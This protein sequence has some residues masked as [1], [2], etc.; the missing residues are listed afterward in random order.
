M[1]VNEPRC[2]AASLASASL[3]VLV[4]L[5]ASA[6]A[7]VWQR[8]RPDGTL[9]FTNL[10]PT[11]TRWVPVGST[12]GAHVEPGASGIEPSRS[13][14]L[15]SRRGNTWWTRSHANG[16]Q[17][18]TNI[19]PAGARWKVLFRT[20]PGKASSLRGASDIVPPRDTSS[21][22][23]H[24]YDQHILDQ[25]AFY[26]M[27]EELMRA[28]IKTES[29]FDPNV[30]S[31]AGAMGLMQLMPG[32]ARAMGVTDVWDPRQNIMGGARYLQTMARLFCRTPAAGDKIRDSRFTCSD[33][34]LVSVLAG[35]HAGPNAV[36]KYAGMP[37]YATTRAYVT[38]V[39]SRYYDYRR[40]EAVASTLAASP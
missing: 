1:Y 24:Q 38:T 19:A 13:R 27:P 36:R 2:R 40:G 9:E 26:G 32:T 10:T 6:H 22:R 5:S 16:P 8:T 17:E 29:D 21:V 4:A 14:R 20:G 34:E 7:A 37:P 33:Q 3:I 23:F 35:Y 18:F 39:F 12:P 31:R 28:V 30:V 15:A 11:D 25:Q